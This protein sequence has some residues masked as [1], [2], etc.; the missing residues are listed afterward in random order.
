MAAK[1]KVD[2]DRV[3]GRGGERQWRDRKFSKDIVH[4]RC[5]KHLPRRDR[6][7]TFGDVGLGPRTDAEGYGGANGWRP[8]L[9]SA[10]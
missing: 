10:S 4:H 9:P 7:H 5:T 8:K 2:M 1:G 6:N 3:L